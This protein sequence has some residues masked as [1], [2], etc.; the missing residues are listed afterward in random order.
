MSNLCLVELG[1]EVFVE[2]DE[3]TAGPDDHNEGEE[4]RGEEEPGVVSCQ[5]D[6]LHTS[7]RTRPRSGE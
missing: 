7:V 2:T 1:H 3:E 4:D 5:H 6:S